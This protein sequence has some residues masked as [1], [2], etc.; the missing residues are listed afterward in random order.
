M[1]KSEQHEK[2][3][4]FGGDHLE[5]YFQNGPI[6]ES[7]VN[8]CQVEDVIQVCI[9]RIDYL[10]SLYEKGKFRC[11]ENSLAITKLEEAK[12]WLQHRTELR[13]RQKVEGTSKVHAS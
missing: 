10:N 7:G 2:A 9:D 8:G 12:H 3:F 1:E 6:K 11:R 13:T 4:M 5:I